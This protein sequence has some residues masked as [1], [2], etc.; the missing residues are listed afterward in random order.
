MPPAIE[1][2]LTAR[3]L[4][5]ALIV[6]RFNH[7]ITDQL[8]QG[9][10]DCLR[11]HGA[12]EKALTVVR[13]PGSLEIPPIARRLALSGAY[14]AV[15]CL[16]CVIRGGTDHYHYV[17]GEA[18]KGIAAVALE[19]PVPVIFGVLTADTIEQAIERAGTKM[20]N[21]GADAALTAIEMA[22]LYRAID[23]SH[24]PKTRPR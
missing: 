7:F 5:F 4:R 22:N 12:E 20:G 14:D 17:A 11:R 3:G 24:K 13:V 8:L 16:G 1:G 10:L 2:E 15:I 9:A 18:S 19:S 23:R 21:K 6:S